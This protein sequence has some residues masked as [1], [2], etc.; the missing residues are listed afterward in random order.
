[1]IK[2]TRGAAPAILVSKAEEWTKEFAAF[3]GPQ[4]SMPRA[5]RFRYR[6]TD[7]KEAVRR[8]AAGKCVYCESLV[9]QVHP[10]EIE[11][12]SPVSKRPDLVV[13]WTN[14]TFVCTECNREK[15]D[16][17][18]PELPLLDP[19]EDEP[20]EH[21]AFD[22]PLVLHRTGAPRGEITVRTL[23]LNARKALFERRKERLE[24][25]QILIDRVEALPSGPL[26]EAL[27][28]TLASEVGDDKEYT[29]VGREFVRQARS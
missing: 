26:R 4:A 28:A 20:A 16:Y 23:K 15:R 18:Q 1:M 27:E 6:H 12:V 11:H 21:L 24:Q 25:L 2:R 22:G 29:A 14:L 17:Y 7:I 3:D 8:D 9:N 10:G 19:F 13:E 5:T